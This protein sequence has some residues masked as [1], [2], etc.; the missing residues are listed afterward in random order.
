MTT[1]NK[2]N[3]DQSILGDFIMIRQ[4]SEQE[5]KQPEQ[6]SKQ[7]EQ[8]SK[9]PNFNMIIKM[10]NELW[11]DK[12]K[13]IEVFSWDPFIGSILLEMKLILVIQETTQDNSIYFINRIIDFI[14][15]DNSVGEK[16]TIVKVFIPGS[17][18]VKKKKP[19]DK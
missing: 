12:N 3:L 16:Y 11:N 14:R 2:P 8:E 4:K 15:Q 9:Q 18:V 1:H 13:G 19:P 5:S 7:P 17:F 6:E 10:F